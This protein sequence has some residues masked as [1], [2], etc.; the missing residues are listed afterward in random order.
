MKAF[1]FITQP[2]IMSFEQPVFRIQFWQLRLDLCIG[3]D[4][5]GRIGG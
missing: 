5:I 1:V 2:S 4:I 3:S